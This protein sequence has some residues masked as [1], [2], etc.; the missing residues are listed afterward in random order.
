MAFGLPVVA[1]NVGGLP[2]VVQDG[3]TGI[4]VPP[5]DPNA[6]ADAI[7]RLLRDPELRKRLGSAGRERVLSEFRTDRIVEQT[8]EVYESVRRSHLAAVN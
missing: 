2:E 6:L 7:V 3:V 5:K 8:L 4:L 1:T